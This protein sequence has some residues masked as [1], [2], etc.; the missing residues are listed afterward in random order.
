MLTFL[1]FLA[2]LADTLS[3]VGK[4]CALFLINGMLRSL[5]RPFFRRNERLKPFFIDS[6]F[7]RP[8]HRNDESQRLSCSGITNTKV[9]I[10]FPRV[11]SMSL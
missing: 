7:Q 9:L 6:L 3:R 1:S 8:V 4:L 5:Y 11:K 10:V 2:V